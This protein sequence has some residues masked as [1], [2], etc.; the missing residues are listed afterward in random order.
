MEGGGMAGIGQVTPPYSSMVAPGTTAPG[1]TAPF[2]GLDTTGITG[3]A[4]TSGQGGTGSVS[5]S[6]FGMIGDAAPPG[7]AGRAVLAI[8]GSFFRWHLVE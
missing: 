1:T 8:S 7:P 3:G 5:A 4:P 2:P 6:I